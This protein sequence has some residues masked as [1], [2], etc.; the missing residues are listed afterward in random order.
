MSTEE[1][2]E[3]FFDESNAKTVHHFD[4]MS[5]VWVDARFIVLTNKLGALINA[6]E[7]EFYCAANNLLLFEWETRD[8]LTADRLP[9]PQFKKPI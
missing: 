7:I 6:S 1:L 2:T 5:L 8:E 3:S 4:L 9:M